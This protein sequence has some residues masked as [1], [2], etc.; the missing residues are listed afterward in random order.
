MKSAPIEYGAVTHAGRKRVNQDMLKVAPTDDRS[1]ERGR[2][3][4]V[5][6]GMGGHNGGEVASRLACQGLDEYY[7]RSISGQPPWSAFVLSRH[8]EET[9]LRIDRLL[10]LQ[11]FR[12]AALADMGTT[13]SCLVITSEHTIIAHVGDSRIYRLRRGYLT[14]LTT[15]HTF[16]QD[17]IFEG[18]IDPK[19]AAKHPMRHFLTRAVGTPESLDQADVR[20]DPLKGGDRFLLCSDGLFN[21]LRAEQI[22]NTLS[23][24]WPTR[25]IAATLVSEALYA[26]ARDNITALV[27]KNDRNQHSGKA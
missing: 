14:C 20:V 25:R 19:N 22:A 10:R 24:S 12:N 16:V 4:A 17:M 21:S 7:Q 1:S 11:G 8:L 3:F 13:L 6:D 2:I 27:V 23:K 15:D 9:V 18:E 26:G 5:A